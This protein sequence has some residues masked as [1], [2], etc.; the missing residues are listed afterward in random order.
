MRVRIDEPGTDDEA[1][2]VEHPGVFGGGKLLHRNDPA[3]L[4]ENVAQQVGPPGGIEQAS[5]ADQ[6]PAHGRT[7]AP[8]LAIS[9]RSGASPRSRYSTAILTATPLV[10][11]LRITEWGPSATSESISTPRFMGPG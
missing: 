1:A 5:A 8:D 2:R 9:A 7:P 4:D 6:E 3:I 11:C 10:T